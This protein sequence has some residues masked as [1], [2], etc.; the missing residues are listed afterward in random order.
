[1]NS[2]LLTVAKNEIG[3]TE[4]PGMENNP[5]ILHYANRSGLMWVKDD[6]TSWCGIFMAFC[7]SEI[8]ECLKSKKYPTR[9]AAR[10]RSWLNYGAVVGDIE[11]AKPGD[12]IVFWRDSID[13]WKGH[14]GIYL[15]HTPNSIL[16]L[17]G[18]QSNQVNETWLDRSKVL[19]VR[20]Y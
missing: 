12:V 19:G 18:N 13:S 5:R 7:L 8:P 20:R 14:V 15:D 16:T 4:I 3:V 17:G 10:A 2:I 9:E 11:D 6:E 1:M